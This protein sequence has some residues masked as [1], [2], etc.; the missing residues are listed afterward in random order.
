MNIQSSW[1]TF[2][3]FALRVILA[4]TLT[5][6]L[7]G[8]IMSNVFDYAEVFQREII[9]DYMLPMGQHNVLGGP[10]G[11]P[12]RGCLWRENLVREKPES[13]SLGRGKALPSTKTP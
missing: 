8:M 1:K 4:H 6:F 2:L 13:R 12:D 5:Y 7:F 3:G 11:H 9:R 10:C